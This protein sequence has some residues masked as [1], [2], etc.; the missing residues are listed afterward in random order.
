MP[1]EEGH[2]RTLTSFP[3][4][5]LLRL[6]S[7]VETVSPGHCGARLPAPPVLADVAAARNPAQGTRQV[8]TSARGMRC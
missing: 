4:G 6:W 1:R 5:G 3:A 8:P 7:L 2:A